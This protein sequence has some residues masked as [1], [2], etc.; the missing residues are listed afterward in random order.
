MKYVKVSII[1][2]FMLFVLPFAVAF[3]NS[4][5]ISIIPI[6]NAMNGIQD[7][8]G[9]ADLFWGES[10]SD[11]QATHTTKFLEYQ[12]G[13]ASYRIWIPD[14]HGSLYFAG[15]VDVR[16]VFRANKLIYILIR[17]SKETIPQR[18]VGMTKLYG[19][20]EEPSKGFYTWKGPFSLIIMCEMNNVGMLTLAE[21]PQ[22][23]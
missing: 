11:V 21:I 16:G 9:F 5:R 14:A 23:K 4:S 12:S 19:A 1:T 17:F 3:T 15:P 18:V 6:A 13:T 22:Q 7:P 2:I 20:P 8:N 10:L